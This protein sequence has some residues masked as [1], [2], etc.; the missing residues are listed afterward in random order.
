MDEWAEDDLKQ[1]WAKMLDIYGKRMIDDHGSEINP[2]WRES[3]TKMSLERVA[4]TVAIC[5]EAG[6]AHPITLSQFVKRSK[7]FRLDAPNEFDLLPS[8][9]LTPERIEENLDRLSKE[10]KRF[11]RKPG[12]R[13]SVLLPRE[14]YAQ[15]QELLGQQG[16]QKKKA[17]FILGRVIKNGW[18]VQ[19]EKKYVETAHSLG[20]NVYKGGIIPDL[21]EYYH[22]VETP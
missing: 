21:S 9:N 7:S 3:I 10:T 8:P 6:D 19:D 17:L 15:F 14:N 5:L 12:Q 20:I 22:L 13:R 4:K 11:K 18:T 16:T 1:F 2:T